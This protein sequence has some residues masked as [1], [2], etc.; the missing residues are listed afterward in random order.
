MTAT[1]SPPRKASFSADTFG[2]YLSRIGATPLLDAATEVTLAKRIEA[3]LYAQHLLNHTDDLDAQYRAD[4]QTVATQGRAARDRMIRANLRLVVSVARVWRPR[5]SGMSEC[6]I[7]QEGNVGLIKAVEKFDY[8]KGFKFSTYA[9]WWIRQALARALNEQTRTIRLPIHIEEAISLVVRIERELLVFNGKLPSEAEIAAG[10]GISI[11]RLSE[12]RRWD[13]Q[14]ISTNT[15]VTTNSDCEYGDIIAPDSTE[16][17]DEYLS[18]AF[19]QQ[20][21]ACLAGLDPQARLVL[22]MRYGLDGMPPLS[23]AKVATALKMRIQKVDAI[24]TGAMRRLRQSGAL[25][26][27]A[28]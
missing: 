25:A 27:W 11:E 1:M 22:E 5:G 18:K 12:I 2:D 15:P 10:A 17:T 24:E 3:G 23:R 8:R 13:K 9:T 6:D 14:V 21:R 26:D 28:S 19:H 20:M 7:V 16:V 4:L